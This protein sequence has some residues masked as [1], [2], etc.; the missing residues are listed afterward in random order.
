V[1][2]AWKASA[3]KVN[4]LKPNIAI[5]ASISSPTWD[6]QDSHNSETGIL[7]EV[8]PGGR[9]KTPTTELSSDQLEDNDGQNSDNN[10]DIPEYGP[11]ISRHYMPW[12]PQVDECSFTVG[13][14]TYWYTTDRKNYSAAKQYCIAQG[15]KMAVIKNAEEMIAIKALAK[16]S[17][18][19]YGSITFWIPAVWTTTSKGDGHFVIDDE[20]SKV[21]FSNPGSEQTFPPSD[22]FDNLGF[23]NR[24]VTLYK[25]VEE[26]KEEKDEYHGRVAVYAD[27]GR[28]IY[29]GVDTPAYSN[30]GYIC[31]FNQCPL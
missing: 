2:P 29:A 15:G 10:T 3:E 14:K 20:T 19:Y 11:S 26:V 21:A 17:T 30:A 27:N 28:W 31:Q 22:C 16:Q 12:Q 4:F 25:S 9:T 1:F 5:V 6:I 7:C 8:G 23:D 13:S 24:Y 18:V